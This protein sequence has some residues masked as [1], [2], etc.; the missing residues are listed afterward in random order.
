MQQKKP[1]TKECF[2][3]DPIYIMFENRPNLSMVTEVRMMISGW[4]MLGVGVLEVV[5]ARLL[6]GKEQEGHFWAAGNILYLNL[7]AGCTCK[8]IF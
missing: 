2:L 4:E 5:Q 1:H 7:R 8:F 6:S 3:H